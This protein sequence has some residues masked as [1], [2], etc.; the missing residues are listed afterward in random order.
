MKMSM[1]IEAR[2]KGAHQGQ[3]DIRHHSSANA[4]A[5]DKLLPPPFSEDKVRSHRT[6]NVIVRNESFLNYFLNKKYILVKKFKNTDVTFN[7]TV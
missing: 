5:P 6:L 4:V 3:H 1:Q 2:G 7:G